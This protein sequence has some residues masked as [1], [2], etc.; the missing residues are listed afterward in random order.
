MRLWR[1]QKK[2]RVQMGTS[3]KV[4]EMG[5]RRQQEE[6]GSGVETRTQSRYENRALGRW[7]HP[8]LLMSRIALPPRLV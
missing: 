4:L 2:R 3:G 1:P 7:P 8:Q 5:L 6:S